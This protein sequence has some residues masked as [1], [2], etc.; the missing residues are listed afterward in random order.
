MNRDSLSLFS[1]ILYIS[2]LGG[3]CI[4]RALNTIYKIK[5]TETLSTAQASPKDHFGCL[6]VSR[7]TPPLSHPL[8][9]NHCDLS[10]M[11]SD[12][13]TTAK[14]QPL[15]I[16]SPSSFIVYIHKCT[17]APAGLNSQYFKCTRRCPT[18][19][20]LCLM[21][22]CLVISS[23]LCK[24]LIWLTFPYHESLKF[25]VPSKK[26]LSVPFTFHLTQI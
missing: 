22:P 16:S 21:F 15:A 18:S 17:Y 2:T 12:H 23:L 26:D 3:I 14:N 5:I 25:K 11:W 10:K 6:S 20:S 7:L 13:T 8:P 1:Y 24:H 9:H 4:V 19:R